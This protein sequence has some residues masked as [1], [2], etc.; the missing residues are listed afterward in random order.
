[1]KENF[2]SLK[3]VGGSSDER[4]EA[5]EY[6]QNRQSKSVES[7]YG[8]DL[9]EK[10]PEE[11]SMIEK[12]IEYVSGIARRYGV[13]VDISADRIVVVE[14][15]SLSDYGGGVQSSLDNSIAIERERS[16]VLFGRTVAH[17]LFH[18]L[19][20]RS[21]QVNTKSGSDRKGIPYRSGISMLARDGKVEY[22]YQAEEA[23]AAEMAKSFFID[24]LSNDEKFQQEITASEAIKNWMIS[25]FKGEQQ[26]QEIINHNVS[27]VENIAF[28]PYA[29]E[30]WKL[31]QTSDKSDDYKMGS[32]VGYLETDYTEGTLRTERIAESENFKSILNK[33]VETD[34]SQ[35]LTVEELF[36]LFARAHFT[37]NYLP[38]AKRIDGAV[39]SGTFRTVAED[40]G[41]KFD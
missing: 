13:E 10:T 37:G 15:G 31:I 39:G 41:V 23:M 6:I 7:I 5:S 19:A 34:S 33:L 30:C 11:A 8:E 27:L 35:S 9:L 12:T 20:Y 22:L 32:I 24:V 17:E 26:S 4:I 25:S 14:R 36:D 40:L 21:F 3:V 16:L 2:P 18:K 29:V 1:M 28:F 38:L